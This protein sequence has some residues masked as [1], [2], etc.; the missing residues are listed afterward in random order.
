MDAEYD[1]GPAPER[2]PATIKFLL[3]MSNCM[4]QKLFVIHVHIPEAVAIIE[5]LP[6][7][8]SAEVFCIASEAYLIAANTLS[9]DVS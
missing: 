1:I 3:H 5:P 8:F 9:T 4:Y 7:G 6:A 2:T